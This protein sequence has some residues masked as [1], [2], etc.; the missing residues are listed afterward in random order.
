[1]HQV[2]G[3]TDMALRRFFE[4]AS[5]QPWYNN[6]LFVIV[7]DH[8]VGGAL[9]KYKTSVGS[10]RIPILFF[11]PRGELIGSEANSVASQADLYP[12]ILDLVGDTKPMIAFSSSL[13]D[14]SRPRFTVCNLD[15]LYQMIEGDWVLHFDGEHVTGLYNLRTDPMQTTDLKAQPNTP[16]PTM[17]L[18]L[19]AY[20]QEYTHRMRENRLT[21]L[22]PSK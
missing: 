1:M 4:T 19:K 15:G 10:V 6:T 14:T 5:K 9:D 20:L 3:Y 2:I 11:D 16:L 12:T 7:A 8:A 13:F 18:R 22:E 21:S 17:L